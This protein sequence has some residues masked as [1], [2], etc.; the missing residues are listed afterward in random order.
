[1]SCALDATIPPGRRS[2]PFTDLFTV[3][4]RAKMRLPI[5]DASRSV[6][7]RDGPAGFFVG[8]NFVDVVPISRKNVDAVKVLPVAVKAAELKR[9]EV[10]NRPLA[11]PLSGVAHPGM[12]QHRDGGKR[13]DGKPQC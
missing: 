2:L 8:A 11:A 5:Q 10:L 9:I 4:E 12:D 13:A 1:M 6:I 7:K 3:G